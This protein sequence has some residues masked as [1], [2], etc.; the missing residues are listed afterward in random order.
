MVFVEGR[1]YTRREIADAVG[2]SI[3]D[4]L[5]HHNGRVVCA[6]LVPQLNPGA[7]DV[8]LV[9]TGPEIV[10]W[11]RVFADQRDFVPV[12]I[13]RATNAWEHVGRYRV[14]GSSIDT[15]EISR[16]EAS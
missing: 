13:K 14:E 8:I 1:P 2:G 9:G 16:R 15:A 6:C 5:P 7:P 3:Q 4:Y 10:R 11:A 12:F